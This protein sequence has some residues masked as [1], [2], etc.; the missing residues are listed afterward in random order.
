MSTL[1]YQIIRE[2]TKD[3]I[4]RGVLTIRLDDET[5]KRLSKIINITCRSKSDIVREAIF[6]L[7][8]EKYRD[9]I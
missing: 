1:K 9:I 4:K 3:Q 5:Q 6:D 7:I 8:W 2:F